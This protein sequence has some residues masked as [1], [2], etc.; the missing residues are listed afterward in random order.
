MLMQTRILF[1]SDP[2]ENKHARK[3]DLAF[4]ELNCILGTETCHLYLS[5]MLFWLWYRF[6]IVWYWWRA[7]LRKL[8][9]D[10]SFRNDTCAF[11]KESTLGKITVAGKRV[12]CMLLV[13]SSGWYKL[14]YTTIQ[15][16]LK[17]SA[18]QWRQ[19]DPGDLVTSFS[20]WNNQSVQGRK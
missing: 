15:A 3:Q 20:V 17:I 14:Q 5:R 1:I 2:K 16:F 7:A 10:V 9:N 11:T 19:F 18:R 13:R 12:L 4:H 6:V 8:T